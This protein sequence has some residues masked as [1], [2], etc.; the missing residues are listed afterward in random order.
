MKQQR[1][2]PFANSRTVLIGAALTAFVAA[3]TAVVANDYGIDNDFYDYAKVLDVYP[4]TESVK[5]STPV[6]KCWNKP[7]TYYSQHPVKRKNKS[8]TPEVVGAI[9]GAAVGNRFGKGSGRDAATVAGALLGGSIARDIK[10]GQPHHHTRTE[11]HTRMERHCETHQNISYDEQVVG[12]DVKYRYHGNVFT[13][14]MNEHPGKKIK[15]RVNLT[16]VG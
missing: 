14:R 12:Y 3:S 13:T 11:S 4:I 15:V 9:V 5:I 6:E 2:K 16:P 1:M 10:H 7:V 8:Y